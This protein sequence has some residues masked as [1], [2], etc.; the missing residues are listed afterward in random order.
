MA[1]KKICFKLYV[2]LCFSFFVAQ[3]QKSYAN[4]NEE[5]TAE[6]LVA[7]HVKSIG[8]SALLAKV[9]SRSFVGSANVDF[10]L[11]NTGNLK[12]NSM[13]VSQGSNLAISLKYGD[14]NYPG[15][16]FAYD[17]KAVTVD[18]IRP[19]Q[20]SPIA[21]F[22][23]RFNKIMKGGFM[24]GSLSTSWPLLDIKSKN[25]DMKYR[26]TKID[27]IERHELEYHP[28]DGFGDMKI[29]MYFDLNTFQHV[30]TEYRVRVKD[31]ATVGNVATF[32]QMGDSASVKAT[33]GGNMMIGQARPDTYYTL[34]EKFDDYKKVSGMMLPHRYILEYS[35]EGAGS[36]I[37][38]W[39]LNVIKWAF[40]APNL[41]PKIFQAQ[42]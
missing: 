38:N 7:A 27:G 20:K 40:N 3:Q 32:D 14:T 24:G 15:E 4:S 35:M 33:I 39:T 16:Y 13:F 10:I 6:K 8:S 17:G 11:G 25:V 36:F 2:L 18:H 19:G 42:K 21:D 34:I 37:A 31:D 12:G 5:M 22:L 29:R 9:Q 1:R 41:N 26:K 23:F 28:R 30:R